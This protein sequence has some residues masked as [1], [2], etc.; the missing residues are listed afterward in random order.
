MKTIIEVNNS[1]VC[2]SEGKEWIKVDHDSE[3]PDYDD[4]L[5][6][7]AD[8]IMQNLHNIEFDEPMTLTLKKVTD[9]EWKAADKLG[10][11]L[12]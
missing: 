3:W 10:K 7:A 4:F 6:D 5:R 2:D 8:S 12:S 9:D 1:G 11:K